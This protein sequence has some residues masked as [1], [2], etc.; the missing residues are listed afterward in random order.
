MSEETKAPPPVEILVD[1][2]PLLLSSQREG[3]VRLEPLMDAIGALTLR[4]ARMLQAAFDAVCQ[5]FPQAPGSSRVDLSIK[6]EVERQLSA[7][8]RGGVRAAVETGGAE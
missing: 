2:K 1:G 3:G 7:A 6:R 8:I 5:R 4:D